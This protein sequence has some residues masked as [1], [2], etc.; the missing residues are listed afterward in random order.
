MNKRKRQIIHAARQLFIEKGYNNTF[1]NDIISAANISK[2]TFYNHFTSKSEC[3]I[4]ILEETREETISARYQV[5]INKE[6]NDKTVLVKQISLLIHVNRKR[7]LIQIF[8]TLV[9]NADKEIKTVLEK[10]LI[11]E[12][13][14][15]ASRFIDVYG[16]KIRDIAYEC[17]VQTTGMIQQTIRTITIATNQLVSPEAVIN[18]VLDYIDAMIPR[19]LETK[20]LTIT[21]EIV[22]ALHL[23]IEERLVTKESLIEQLQGFIEKLP[24]D[25]PENGI[26]LSNY[27][28]KELQSIE[29]KI[30]VLEAILLS[31]NKAFKNTPHEAEANEITIAFWRYLNGKKSG[32]NN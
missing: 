27:L 21:P 14:W 25:Y 23:K 6:L 20:N 10:H 9:G 15:L 22:Q 8:E 1:V 5:G 19:L 11:L 28:L 16:E 2:G 26:E 7:N 29:E 12:L 32:G 18:S 4:A 3:L 24:N 31:F 30:Y 17:A 13:E